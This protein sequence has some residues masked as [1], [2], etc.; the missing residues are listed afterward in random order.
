MF[1]RKSED[2]RNTDKMVRALLPSLGEGKA[3]VY[4]GGEKFRF[5]GTYDTWA[6]R[7]LLRKL[8]DDGFIVWS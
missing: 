6:D 7:V 4:T 2:E 3:N 5:V 1:G 8:Q